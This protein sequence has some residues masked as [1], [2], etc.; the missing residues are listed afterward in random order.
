M[1]R[2]GA[3]NGARPCGDLGI[4]KEITARSVTWTLEAPVARDILENGPLSK[5]R[6][7]PESPL[8]RHT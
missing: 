7:H 2:P 6:S 3:R 4:S 5:S 8:A 1:A